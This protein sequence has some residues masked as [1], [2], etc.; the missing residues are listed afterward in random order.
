MDS[1]TRCNS[2]KLIKPS[3]IIPHKCYSGDLPIEIIVSDLNYL[4]SRSKVGYGVF[5]FYKIMGNVINKLKDKKYFCRYY[6]CDF[7]LLDE[8]EVIFM[9]LVILDY[10]VRKISSDSY[11]KDL[12]Q[13][14]EQLRIKCQSSLPRC[15]RSSKQFQ[16]DNQVLHFL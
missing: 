8:Q 6:K 13:Q 15:E 7:A 4:R 2:F 10:I 12:K 5:S 16:L 11:F 1:E 9:F 14:I 3:F